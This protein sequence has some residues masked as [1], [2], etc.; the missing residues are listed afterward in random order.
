[1]TELLIAAQMRAIEEA[2]MAS[3]HV[4]GLQLMERAGRGIVAAVFE[5]WPALAPKDWNSATWDQATKEVGKT[6]LSTQG[7]RAFPA[8]GHAVIL[9]GPGNNGGDGYVVARLLHEFGWDVEVMAFAGRGAMPP[10]AAENRRRWLELGG[11]VPLSETSFRAPHPDRGQAFADIY[12]D[13]LF[14]AGLSRPL[15]GEAR[16]I[17]HHMSGIDGDDYPSRT[18]A[19]DA[20]SGLCLDS[21][22]QLRAGDTP[23]FG[24]AAALTVTFDLPKAGHFLADGPRLC[25]EIAVKDI[26]IET[27]RVLETRAA[28]PQGD[29]GAIGAQRRARLHLVMPTPL[30]PDTRTSLNHRFGASLIKSDPAAHKYSHGHALVLA[31]TMGATG[32]ARLAARAALR[33]G[34]GLVTLGAPGSALMECAVHST[35][36]MVRRAGTPDDLSA[37]LEDPRINAVCLGPGFG[38]ARAG[39]HLP[40]LLE[41]VARSRTLRAVLDADALTALAER[42]EVLAGL[43]GDIVLTPHMGEF[44]RLFPE[45][46]ARLSANAEKGPAYSKVDAVRDAAASCGAVVL[47]KGPDTVIADAR[48]LAALHA[49]QYDRAAPWLATAG[50]GDV[51]AGLITGLLARGFG[52]MDAAAKGAW[53]HAECARAFGAGLI[54]E[55][56]PEMLPRVLRAI[57]VE[58]P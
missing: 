23:A 22:R 19:V 42:P 3:G 14:G 8:R 50:S 28:P 11:L 13:A 49:A 55:D 37:C 7:A 21:G 56:L 16:A 51:L 33:V 4:T 31:G 20:P 26:G 29:R 57:S 25:G 10:D 43:N 53:L 52:A 48:G 17:L 46:G 54:S 36:V 5:K 12:V 58:A 47:L 44:A 35:A 39:E 45:I 1:M 34:A 18:V 40:G 38:I 27:W 6:G 2:A 9:C 30:V 15:A 32:A 41:A 24:R